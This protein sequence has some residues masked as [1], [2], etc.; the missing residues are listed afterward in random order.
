MI[1]SFAVLFTRDNPRIYLP[2][3]EDKVSLMWRFKHIHT[4]K[5]KIDQFLKTTRDSPSFS[6]M[7]KCCPDVGIPRTRIASFVCF[8]QRKNMTDLLHEKNG[9]QSNDS[10]PNEGHNNALLGSKIV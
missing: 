1:V 2:P 7:E 5:D 10:N 9:Y 4:R 8:G 3:H 6:G